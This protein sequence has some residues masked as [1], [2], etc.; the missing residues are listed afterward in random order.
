MCSCPADF[1]DCCPSEITH[2]ITITGSLVVD[3]GHFLENSKFRA[4]GAQMLS[5]ELLDEQ[6][7]R[8]KY[9]LIS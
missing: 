8:L 2:L 9:A 6:W 1:S 5:I 4:V 7:K 3:R